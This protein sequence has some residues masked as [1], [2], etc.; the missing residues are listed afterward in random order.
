[1]IFEI[2]QYSQ[3]FSADSQNM[4]KASN[5][6]L[7]CKQKTMEKLILRSKKNFKDVFKTL[8]VPVTMQGNWIPHG[9]VTPDLCTSYPI[10]EK[11]M[12]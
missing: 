9:P 2:K 3:F 6:L 1:M 8:I 5:S 11:I 4:E 10:L 12:R 7:Q